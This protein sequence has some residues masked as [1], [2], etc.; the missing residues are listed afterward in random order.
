MSDP[1]E[2]LNILPFFTGDA[3]ILRRREAEQAVVEADWAALEP[4]EGSYDESAWNEL[5]YA[6]MAVLSVGTEPVLCLYNGSEPAWFREKGGW[7]QE[8]NLRCYLRFV[9]RTV[10]AAGHLAARYLTFCDVNAHAWEG[11]T[12]RRALL[13]MSHMACT[14]VRA[15]RLLHDM[16]KDRGWDDTAVGFALRMYPA[17]SL[18]GG[19]PLKTPAHPAVYQTAPLRAMARGSFLLPLRNVL[20]IRSGEWCDFVGVCP[21]GAEKRLHVGVHPVEEMAPDAAAMAE[22]CLAAGLLTEKPVWL[23]ERNKE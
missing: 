18:R 15:Y 9:A 3:Q 16:R 20:R 10:R 2:Q 13:A 11:R 14:H 17:P 23:L 5:R 8:D 12:M 21:P 19:V 22:C 6:L 7:E 1:R 4:E